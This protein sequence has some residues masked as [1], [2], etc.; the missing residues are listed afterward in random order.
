MLQVVPLPDS[1]LNQITLPGLIWRLQPG[2][3]IKTCHFLWWHNRLQSIFLSWNRPACRCVWLGVAF[4][5]CRQARAVH[6]FMHASLFMH[7]GFLLLSS[8]FLQCFVRA[9]VS[10]RAVSVLSQ[11]IF[12]PRSL[13]HAL[14]P[15]PHFLKCL[16]GSAIPTLGKL[17]LFSLL[18]AL[19]WWIEPPSH[20]NVCRNKSVSHWRGNAFERLCVPN[21]GR[22]GERSGMSYVASWHETQQLR[23]PGNPSPSFYCSCFTWAQLQISFT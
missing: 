19:L 14:S 5:L 2:R 16:C 8:A 10:S 20:W 4:C 13:Q 6:A 12:K 18:C 7:V 22:L 23:V 15:L 1:Y 9:H 21:R 17:C 11:A 3:Q